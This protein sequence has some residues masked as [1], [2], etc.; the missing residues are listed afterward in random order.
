MNRVYIAAPYVAR[1]HIRELADEL[2]AI[3]Y[4]VTSRWLDE[5]HEIGASTAGAATGLTDETVS[6]HALDDLAD[7]RS[8]DVF[9]AVTAKQSGALPPFGNSGGRHVEMGYAL[10]RELH[11]VVVGEPENIFQRMKT[12]TV[13][14]DWHQAVVH[15]S[16][17]LVSAER[18]APRPGRAS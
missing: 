7:V 15:L 16:A 6:R 18:C 9:V 4:H 2:I 13:V 5:T 3:G 8:A 17:R 1:D 11:I 12:V 10:A 14:R